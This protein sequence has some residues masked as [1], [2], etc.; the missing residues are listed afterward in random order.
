MQGHILTWERK[1]DSDSKGERLSN[2]S[3][4]NFLRYYKALGFVPFKSFLVLSLA[5]F[6]HIMLL[7]D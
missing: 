7:G 2:V 4:S 6:V 3:T 1:A 5:N